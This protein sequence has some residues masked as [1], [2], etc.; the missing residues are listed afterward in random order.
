MNT[1]ANLRNVGST[2]H[3][4]ES[5]PQASCANVEVYWAKPIFGHRHPVAR[6]GMKLMGFHPQ[7]QGSSFSPSR[8]L[9]FPH[10]PPAPCSTFP[11]GTQSRHPVLPAA[12]ATAFSTMSAAQGLLADV[13]KLRILVGHLQGNRG[14]LLSLP[15][16][17]RR[18]LPTASCAGRR[19]RYH[20]R[21]S[22]RE[23]GLARRVFDRRNAMQE[24]RPLQ[25]TR[26][27]GP[28]CLS[29]LEKW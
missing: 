8:P 15:Y 9:F 1:P 26:Q 14:L 22:W 21:S 29:Y 2:V 23:P 28:R 17:P 25:L 13:P 16:P 4:S 18:H 11:T 7:G 24:H 3:S 27:A 20:L 19:A 5:W 12:S 10:L 6:T